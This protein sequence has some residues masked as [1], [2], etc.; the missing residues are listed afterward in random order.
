MPGSTFSPSAK[1]T[2]KESLPTITFSQ[3]DLTGPEN[4][5]AS[6]IKQLMNKAKTWE[7]GQSINWSQLGTKYGL[8]QPNRGQII[9][10][11]S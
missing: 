4:F 11:F 3:E 7:D 2:K 5:G 1:P 10:V 6:L 9:R 8:D